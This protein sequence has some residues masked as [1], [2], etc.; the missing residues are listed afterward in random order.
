MDNELLEPFD[1]MLA[2]AVPP[3]AVRRVDAG[4]DASA[5]WAAVAQSGFLDA[6][7]SEEADG[8]GLS[9]AEIEPLLRALGSRT[10]PVPVAETMV[11]RALLATAG[12]ERPD[13]PIVLATAARTES[14]WATAAVPL[15][16]VAAHA[17][18]E[19]GEGA[20]VLVDL[21]G[22]VVEATGVHGSRGGILRLPAEPTARARISVEEG[23]LRAAA[24]TLRAAAIAGAGDR[25]LDMTAAY[26]NERVQFGKPI[27]RQQAIQQQLAVMA[28]H[29][30]AARIAAQYGCARGLPVPQ[31]AAAI[32]KTVA[33]Q[34][35]T[36]LA[37]IAHA[38]HGAI[39]ISE[40]YDLQLFTR[41]LHEWRLAD[42]SEGY[43]A[44][45]LGAARVKSNAETS[46]GFV[47]G[48][49]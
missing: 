41:R 24:A 10:V 45:L 21:D 40:E 12:V 13:G 31:R 4:G 47:R 28:E 3:E 8:F 1:R 38:V 20:A 43:W 27:G 35:A 44:G 25:L 6:L 22:D 23:A 32:A 2:D 15:A 29:A 30:I 48:A 5:I 18:V 37:T 33:S 49:A 7:V 16:G 36:P 26:A 42:G 14:G 46:I 39:G 19:L 34:A 9:L 11:A 17:L